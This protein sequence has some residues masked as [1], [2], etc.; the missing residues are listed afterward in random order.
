MLA[1]K[2][3]NYYKIIYK[4]FC[5]LTHIL[6]AM[7]QTKVAEILSGDNFVFEFSHGLL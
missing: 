3:V 6:W 5:N 1:Y 4:I 2:Q 7:S